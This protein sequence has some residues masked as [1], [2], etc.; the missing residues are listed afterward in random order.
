MIF[1]ARQLQE[2]CQEQNVGILFIITHTERKYRT[3]NWLSLILSLQ[4]IL[5]VLKLQYLSSDLP[6]CPILFLV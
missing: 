2:K 3:V 6:N 1:T 5:N 4:Q